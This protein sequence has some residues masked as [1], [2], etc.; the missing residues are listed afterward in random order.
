MRCAAFL[1]LS[2]LAVGAARADDDPDMMFAL[3][4]IYEMQGQ[5]LRV[6]IF[7]D[8]K[9]W[10]NGRRWPTHDDDASVCLQQGDVLITASPDKWHDDGKPTLYPAGDIYRYRLDRL[11]AKT[12]AFTLT[13]YD[14]VETTLS[15]TAKRYSMGRERV[16]R[17]FT[18][19]LTKPDGIMVDYGPNHLEMG[20]GLPSRSKPLQ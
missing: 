4:P 5:R 20:S 18:L 12:A 16:V 2:A 8:A 10:L 1:L 13:T 14:E 19:D 9:V 6:G 11:D 3:G 15:P 17:T 7:P